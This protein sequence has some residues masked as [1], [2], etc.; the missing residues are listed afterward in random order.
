LV[1][2]ASQEVNDS[3]ASQETRQA[4]VDYAGA[5]MNAELLRAPM[6]ARLLIQYAIFFRTLGD[7]KD[8]QQESAQALANSPRKQSILIESGIELF[9]SGDYSGA[10]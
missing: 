5:Q 9:Q 2:F 4:I 6:D 1:T 3:N 7:Y 10:R 8:A